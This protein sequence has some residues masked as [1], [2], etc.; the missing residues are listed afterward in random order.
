MYEYVVKSPIALGGTVRAVGDVISGDDATE[1][2]KYENRLR[3]R[4]CIRREASA[5]DSAPTQAKPFAQ[6]AK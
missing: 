5:P 1:L 4:N 2:E 6:E 3:I